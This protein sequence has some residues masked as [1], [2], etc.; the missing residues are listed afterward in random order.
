MDLYNYDEGAS[1][2]WDEIEIFPAPPNK[3]IMLVPEEGTV[4]ATESADFNVVLDASG[5]PS[6][7]YRASVIARF[8]F[9]GQ[10]LAIGEVPV[11]LVVDTT[12]TGVKPSDVPAEFRLLQNVPNPFNITTTMTLELP[13]ASK[14]EVNIYNVTGAHVRTLVNGFEPAGSKRITWDGRNA[15]GEPVATGVYFVGMRTSSFAQT[16]KMVLLK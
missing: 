5:L 2:W 16:R 3:W 7:V 1:A 4:P 15:R 9:A 11:Q 8:D 6:G 14:V 13:R 10:S 12:A